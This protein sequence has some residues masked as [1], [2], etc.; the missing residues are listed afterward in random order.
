VVIGPSG[1]GKTTLVRVLNR[2][3][4][5]LP[6]FKLE[7]QVLLGG[8]NIY[9]ADVDPVLLTRVGMVFQKPN[10]FP[11]SIYENGAFGPRIHKMF[12]SSESLTKLSGK[13]S[14]EQP[15]GTE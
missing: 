5:G 12:R 13:T 3:N 1:C 4:D 7:G 2:M 8:K 10:P 11:I 14:R 6:G 9:P 15:Y